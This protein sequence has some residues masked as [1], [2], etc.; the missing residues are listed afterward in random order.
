MSEQEPTPQYVH[1]V[2]PLAI[3]EAMQ[4]L[5]SPANDNPAEFM[6]E[7]AS[8]KL[9]TNATIANQIDR[10]RKLMEQGSRVSAEE[11]LGLMRLCAR[12]PDAGLVFTSAGRRAAKHAVG[13]V[14][15]GSRMLQ[16]VLSGTLRERHGQGVA[17]RLASL[18]FDLRMRREG[19]RIVASA[20]F[21]RANSVPQVPLCAFYGSAVA[22]LLRTL[23][24][25]DGAMMHTS[26]VASGSRE[27]NW[28]TSPIPGN[29]T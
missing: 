26:C 29:E 23:T 3:L 12:R 5:D 22:E 24:R 28:Q 16:R 1:A 13:H 20:R 4:L 9:G 15:A 6:G 2:I 14:G 17:S 25:F 19:G 18:I 11:A 21:A 8:R 27:C 7:L 10:Y